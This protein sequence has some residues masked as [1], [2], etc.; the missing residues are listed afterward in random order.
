M[1]R[2]NHPLSRRFSRP[3][4]ALGFGC[5]ASREGDARGNILPLLQAYPANA[6]DDLGV[7]GCRVARAYARGFVLPPLR[8]YDRVSPRGY[9]PARLG[10]CLRVH[11]I[12]LPVCDSIDLVRGNRH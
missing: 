2:A 11:P 10:S 5:D 3:S 6:L 12:Y 9:V 7:W 4:G 8:G 1:I